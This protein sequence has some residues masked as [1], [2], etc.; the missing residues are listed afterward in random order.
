MKTF[1]D[2]PLKTRKH[3][4]GWMICFLVCCILPLEAVRLIIVNI[5]IQTQN[6]MQKNCNYE[7]YKKRT[8][9]GSSTYVFI[10]ECGDKIWVPHDLLQNEDY[11][12]TQEELCFSYAEPSGGFF[13]SY[14]CI[15]IT[16]IDGKI[17]FVSMDSALQDIKGRIIVY[18][19]F[20]IPALLLCITPFVIDP[21]L[22]FACKC[23]KSKE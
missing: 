17:Q 4:I 15:E 22:F 9:R 11:L 5:N 3:L 21:I 6:V 1:Y 10:L 19:I 12:T 13:F 23:K 16:S 7:L 2:N 18:L 8:G 14:A 20:G